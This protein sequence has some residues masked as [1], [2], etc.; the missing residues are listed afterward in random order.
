M[1]AQRPD[2]AAAASQKRRKGAWPGLRGPAGHQDEARGQN[3]AH[4][5]RR[6]LDDHGGH[7]GQAVG[8]GFDG[9]R[10]HLLGAA[11]AVSGAA[12]GGAQRHRGRRERPPRQVQHLDH[13]SAPRA[14]QVGRLFR[15]PQQQA[16]GQRQEEAREEHREENKQVDV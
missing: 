13:V 15:L 2:S 14:P 6:Q 4:R 16:G 5:A 12:G 8:R 9:Q 7:G 11:V 3:E 10:P 1:V